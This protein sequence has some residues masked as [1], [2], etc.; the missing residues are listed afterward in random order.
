MSLKPEQP[1]SV[2]Q[3]EVL[4]VAQDFKVGTVI[5]LDW[6]PG[7]A[8]SASQPIPVITTQRERFVLKHLKAARIR[9]DVYFVM[10]FVSYLIGKGIPIPALHRPG[11]NGLDA[12][13]FI[14]EVGD[15]PETLRYYSLERWVQGRDISRKSALAPSLIAA[16]AMVG[17][18]HE[19]TEHFAP[20]FPNTPR[21]SI[22]K[23]RQ[24]LSG[25]PSNTW[26]SKIFTHIGST[27]L[28]EV[29]SYVRE[30]LEFWTPARLEQ[31]PQR[32]IHSDLNFGN[33]KFNDAGDEVVAVLDWD[34]SRQGRFI[35]D[36]FPVLAGTGHRSE[37]LY[38]QSLWQDLTAIRAGYHKF[39]PTYPSF[40]KELE[41][42]LK[43]RLLNHL[44]L[45]ASRMN[46]GTKN[47][48][49]LS[50]GIHDDIV[51]LKRLP[52]AFEKGYGASTFQVSS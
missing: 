11:T 5:D 26:R 3:N 52:E 50:R 19:L 38:M 9:E 36:F 49:S 35:E 1:L 24:L 47:D 17:Q 20:K 40:E 22:D 33:L 21:Y 2:T 30:V 10:D 14:A 39:M 32:A 42:A 25:E 44:A 51:Y 43:I 15:S 12:G 34:Y 23:S 13:N 16:G 41:M 29:E 6:L 28:K 18:I 27:Q 46:G 8:G 37:P 48:D 45:S 4:A 7:G 31:M